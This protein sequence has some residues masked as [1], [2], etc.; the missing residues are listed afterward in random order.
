M[1]IRD[2][3]GSGKSTIAKLISCFKWIE[4][5]LVRGDYNI[6]WFTEENRFKNVYCAYHRLQNYFKENTILSYRGNAYQIDYA[7]G[8]LT[9]TENNTG[10]YELPQIMYVPA[11]RN[12]ISTIRNPELIKLSSDALTEFLTEFDNAKRAIHLKGM[13]LPINDAIVIYDDSKAVSYTHLTLPTI[14]LV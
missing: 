6:Q 3:Q 1:C 7:N 9:I 12:F 11:E 14:L 8:K 5:V 2:S 10:N 4:K 13:S